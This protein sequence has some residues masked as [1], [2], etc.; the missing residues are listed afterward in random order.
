[1][2]STILSSILADWHFTMK[3]ENFCW[4]LLIYL[5]PLQESRLVKSIFYTTHVKQ[6]NIYIWWKKI[7]I[8][9]PTKA[10]HKLIWFRMLQFCTSTEWR[11][12]KKIF[13]VVCW[14]RWKDV[15]FLIQ[16]LKFKIKFCNCTNLSAE[17]S[18]SLQLGGK[19]V[20]ISASAVGQKHCVPPNIKYHA[21]LITTAIIPGDTMMTKL[22]SIKM[23]I[24]WKN[25]HTHT[26][27]QLMSDLGLGL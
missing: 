6:Y 18:C 10:A 5:T 12:K 17:I 26:H 15:S 25:Q 14:W 7:R 9:F 4:W 16:A 19:Y 23:W 24:N 20:Q 1:M 27:T 11:N 21:S 2:H 3:T 8:R 22:C 13:N